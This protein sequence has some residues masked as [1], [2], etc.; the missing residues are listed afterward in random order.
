MAYT[1]A[2]LS[3]LLLLVAIVGFS[4]A[5]DTKFLSTLTADQAIPA[6]DAASVGA[7]SFV[8]NS[9]DKT[10]TYDI[11]YTLTEDATAAHIHGPAGPGDEADPIY[12]LTIADG[13]GATGSLVGTIEDVGS[14]EEGYLEDGTLYVN[15]HT[16]A[17]PNGEIR[18]QIVSLADSFNAK[19]DGAQESPASGSENEG[20]AT[21]SYDAETGLVSV[22]VEHDVD[23]PTAAHIHG[24]AP[25]GENADPVFTFDDASS[26]IEQDFQFTPEQVAILREG[27]MYINVHTEA[28]PNGEIRGQIEAGSGSG[29]GSGHCLST[30]AIVLICVACVG[31]VALIVAGAIFFIR[32]R[33]Q[34]KASYA[35]VVG[36][37]ESSYSPPTISEPFLETNA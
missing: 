33:R 21:I 31:G 30:W 9:D 1:R 7:G 34:Q 18:G 22:K 27:L 15:I 4:C 25:K 17:N 24:P 37:D 5:E 16:N 12:T 14:A 11:T 23:T 36:D 13:S 6:V 32:R 20:E 26:P 8:Y 19:L 3:L 35:L 28:N 29:G 2:S 10:L